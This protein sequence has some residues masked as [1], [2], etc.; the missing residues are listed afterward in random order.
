MLISAVEP[1]IANSSFEQL[2][3]HVP[4]QSWFSLESGASEQRFYTALAGYAQ[5][6]PPIS[7]SIG[8]TPSEI[9]EDDGLQINR[10]LARLGVIQKRIGALVADFDVSPNVSD[11]RR[12]YICEAKKKIAV[13]TVKTLGSLQLISYDS[14]RERKVVE[15]NF[16]FAS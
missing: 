4:I 16:Y 7:V 6:T 12:L 5:A 2:P 1:V 15:R 10:G 11:S 3:P 14:K 9:R 13:G 8:E